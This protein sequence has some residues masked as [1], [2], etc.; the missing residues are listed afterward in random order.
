MGQTQTGKGMKIDLSDHR[1]PEQFLEEMQARFPDPNISLTLEGNVLCVNPSEHLPL[2]I[3][4]NAYES[5]VAQAKYA[6][7]GPGAH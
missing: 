5:L 4:V 6:M 3:V 1:N 2:Q 7:H